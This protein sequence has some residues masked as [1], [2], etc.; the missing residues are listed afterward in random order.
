[1]NGA[2]YV[3]VLDRSGSVQQRVRFD[4]PPIR[5]GRAYDNDVIVDD[6]Y[7]APTHVV[8]EQAESGSLV[9]R[10]AG[11]KNGIHDAAE[12]R[13]PWQSR[14][15]AHCR[16]DVTSSTVLRAG[17]TLL[18]VRPVLHPVPPEQLDTTAHAWEGW[19]PALLAFATLT[20]VSLL[21]SW[22]A[23]T[24]EQAASLYASRFAVL[25]AGAFAWAGLWTLLNRLFGSRTRFGRHLLVTALALLLLLLVDELAEQ[26][27]YSL[28]LAW[29]SKYQLYVLYALVGV[30]VYFHML[31]IRPLAARLARIVG[32][33]FAVTTTTLFALSQYSREHSIAQSAYMD[34]L[35]W[36][37]TRIV[38]P[39]PSA[40]LVSEVERMRSAVDARRAEAPRADEED[41]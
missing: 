12:R 9:A 8:I 23:A 39:V 25:M 29:L 40:T 37:S 33:T 6:P 31:T 22:I 4:G 21:D 19:A 38:E 34:T 3:E 35:R 26:A 27:A 1:M 10:D 36:P 2:L 32:I 15:S 24:S 14:P 17:H 28:S 5:I 7:M 30:A 18:R 41:E 20:L 16:I 11:T 13:T